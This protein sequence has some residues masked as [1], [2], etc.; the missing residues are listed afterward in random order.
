MFLG[1][2][3]VCVVSGSCFCGLMS[4]VGVGCFLFVGFLL[5][6]FVFLLLVAC[7]VLGFVFVVVL[8]CGWHE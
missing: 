3:C 2:W 5:C 4:V 1:C 8:G 6:S 7:S